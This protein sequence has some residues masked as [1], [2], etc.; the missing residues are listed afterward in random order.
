MR[1][2]FVE[3][4]RGGEIGGFWGVRADDANDRGEKEDVCRD[5]V[6][7]GSGGYSIERNRGFDGPSGYDEKADI[8]SLG[9]TAIEAATGSAPHAH[10]HPMR[11]LFVIPQSAPP[12]LP[13]TENNEDNE[14]D[15]GVTYNFS[16]EFRDFVKQCVKMNPE[17][18]P[19]AEEL[20]KHPFLKVGGVN[21]A[22]SA[23]NDASTSTV[24]NKTSNGESNN[25]SAEEREEV[26]TIIAEAK[27][28]AVN[29]AE[30]VRRQTSSLASELTAPPPDASTK[31]EKKGKTRRKKPPPPLHS[32][33]RPDRVNTKKVAENE[34][35]DVEVAEVDKKK[36]SAEERTTPSENGSEETATT[37][38]TQK[39]QTRTL[40][41]VL[42]ARIIPRCL[43]VKSQDQ[44]RRSGT[45]VGISV[46]VH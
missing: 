18:R 17:E 23:S 2:H 42:G 44:N 6:L 36:N 41:V 28:G 45:R 33:P 43:A 16:E 14:E 27:N 29:S 35:N 15:G 40:R 39:K 24:G 13:Y 26:S 31:E 37:P 38:S 32:P 3:R 9:I 46:R 30:K 12:E 8:W 21:A 19:S 22:E 1:E 20:L 34:E 10:L 7:D 4:E 25:A 11:A 5:A